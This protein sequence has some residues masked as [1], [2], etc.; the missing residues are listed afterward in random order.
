MTDF[1][2]SVAIFGAMITLFMTM[3]GLGVD[4]QESFDQEDLLRSQA[5][6]TADFMVT[7]EGYPNNWEETGVEVRI[8]GFA[9]GENILSMEKL[10]AFHNLSYERQTHLTK[11]QNFTLEFRDPQSGE[12]LDYEGDAE[13]NPFDMGIDEYSQA[14]TVINIDRQVAVNRSGELRD[15]EMNYV[16]WR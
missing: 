1:M 3:W 6:R 9:T 11:T 10:E 5:E 12:I 2:A 14:S 13:E 16:V 8:P 4:S 7:T 15:A